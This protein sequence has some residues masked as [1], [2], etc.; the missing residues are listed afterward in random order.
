M[1]ENSKDC[2]NKAEGGQGLLPGCKGACDK[3]RKKNMKEK[4]QDII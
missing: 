1:E 4:E 2:D 3:A